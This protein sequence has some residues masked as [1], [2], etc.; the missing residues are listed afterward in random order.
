MLGIF[1]SIA[2][3]RSLRHARKMRMPKQAVPSTNGCWTDTNYYTTGYYPDDSPMEGGYFDCLGNPLK[4]LQMYMAGSS[5]Y[6][7]LAVDKSIIPLRSVVNIDGYYRYG[8]PV[9][10]WAC[11][12]GGAIKGKHVDICTA[13]AREANKVTHRGVTI[14]V[15]DRRYF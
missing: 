1:F 6:V 5:N 7:S 15:C 2:S 3:C 8:S 14:H 10:F 11:D 4:T 12:V 13:N 9:V